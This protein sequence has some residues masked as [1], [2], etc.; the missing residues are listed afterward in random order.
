[1]SAVRQSAAIGLILVALAAFQD[2]K[3]V[4][5]ISFVII[6][7][8]F[9]SSAMIMA[10][11]IALSYT[12][13]RFQALLL[14]GIAAYPW[15][16]AVSGQFEIYASRYSIERIQSSGALVRIAM[17]VVPALIYIM[18]QRRITPLEEDRTLWRNISLMSIGCLLVYAVFESSTA[19]DR[20]SL[21]ALPIQIYTFTRVPLLV[22]HEGSRSRAIG[23]YLVILL[24][25][26]ILAA[27]MSFGRYRE[28]YIPYHFGFP[29]A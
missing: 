9:H 17:N 14:I 27:Y 4:K 28:G 6:A 19:A 8:M 16:L 26:G 2:R 23:T 25:V 7:A 3:L 12:R 13:N 15:Y 10:P 1:M 21:Y 24:Y 29:A 18:N 11:L 5:A 20:L 22:A